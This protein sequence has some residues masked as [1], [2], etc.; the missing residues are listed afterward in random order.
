MP[1]QS[2]REFFRDRIG[3]TQLLLL[4]CI[5]DI[6]RISISSGSLTLYADD[7]V[8][9]RPVGSSCDYRLLQQDID[10]ISSWTS[11]NYLSHNPTKY[12]YMV[13]SR[14]QQPPIPP[15]SLKVNHSDLERVTAFK[16]F[17]DRISY[18]LSLTTHVSKACRNTRRPIRLLYCHFYCY[19]SQGTLKQL[20][21]SYIRPH[22][23][24]AVPVWDPHLRSHVTTLEFLQKFA[25]KV[26]TKHWNTSYEDL[27]QLSGLPKLAT[28]RTNLN[29]WF[30][31]RV[32]KNV[33][34]Y[35][36]AP[37]QHQTVPT[38]VGN[39]SQYSLVRPL[40]R[41]NNY[42]YSFSHSIFLWNQLPPS[43]QSVPHVNC[44]KHYLTRVL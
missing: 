5:D 42:L 21:T 17:L 12:K 16:Y 30:L 19:W 35:P 40:A 36:N 10:T 31:H 28:R 18:D 38:C 23:E 43:V 34:L 44:L 4:I 2:C 22:L 1:V 14:K 15:V 25:L 3:T 27:L 8:L 20:Y 9:Y 24:Y 13:I 32:L 7:L 26:C 41:T 39:A 33:S 29:L 11:T 6:S 37:L